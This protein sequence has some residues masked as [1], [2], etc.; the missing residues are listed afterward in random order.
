[1][2][3]ESN[4]LNKINIPN[5]KIS[6]SDLEVLEKNTLFFPEALFKKVNKNEVIKNNS[7]NINNSNNSNNS[8]N[9]SKIYAIKP[10]NNRK[11]SYPMKF[12]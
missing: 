3:N 5:I 2:S 6:K 7:I 4:E 1:M 10:Q 9:I 8:N 11:F 12:T